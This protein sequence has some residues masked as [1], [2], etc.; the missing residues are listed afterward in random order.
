[1]K[2]NELSDQRD[3]F[4]DSISHI[5]SKI[6]TVRSYIQNQNASKYNAYADTTPADV[7]KA[8]KGNRKIRNRD[9]SDMGSVSSSPL[10]SS[11]KK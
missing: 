2:M 10:R 4:K 8:K 11:L 5:E 6:G 1:M 3:F 9:Q 7:P